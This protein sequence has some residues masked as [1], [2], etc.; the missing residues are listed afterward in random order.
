MFVVF[1]VG[2]AVTIY[3]GACAALAAATTIV[4][5]IESLVVAFRGFGLTIGR[6]IK[7]QG[8][9]RAVVEGP[10]PAYVAYFLGP[11]W[12]DFKYALQVGFEE[13]GKRRVELFQL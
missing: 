12:S 5:G 4:F 8:G 2:A 6:G 9:D 7:F 11:F 1:A 3:L 10:D 13:L